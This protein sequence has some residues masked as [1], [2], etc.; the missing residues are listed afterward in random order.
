MKKIVHLIALLTMLT[1][2][3]N[4]Q[5]AIYKKVKVVGTHQQ[6]QS[7]AE[8]G[9]CLDHGERKDG[10]FFVSDF[11]PVEFNAIVKSGLKIEV[12]AED[13][14]LYYRQSNNND[15]HKVQAVNCN[16]NTSAPQYA[17]PANFNLGSMGGFLTY[18]ELLA[19][20]DDMATQYPGL[21]TIKQPIGSDTTFEGR[22]VYFVKISDNANSNEPE[23]QAYYT[24]LHHARE[25]LSM[26]QLVYYMWYLLENYAA[27][28][29][30]QYLVD[31]RELYFIPCVNPDGYLYNELTDPLGGGMWRK[32]RRD[33]LD[34][35]MGVDLNRNYPANWGYDDI[36]SSPFTSGE[37]YRG[38][39][40]ASEPEIQMINSFANAHQFKTGLD[41]HSYGNLL[42]YPWG[43]IP[44][45]ETPDSTVFKSFAAVYTEFNRYKAGT[46]SQTVNYT[47]NG[48]SIDWHYGEQTSKPKN[49]DFTPECGY[50]FW[51]AQSD[52]ISLAQD[53]IHI[54]MLSALVAGS[55]AKV[56]DN[57]PAFLSTT[58]GYL[59]FNFQELGLD[60]AAT[61]TVSVTPLGTT[62]NSV[63]NPVA[64]NNPSLM[65]SISDS[66]S[67]SLNANTVVGSEVKYLLSVNFGTYMK[68][69]T[70]VKIYGAPT[71]LLSDDCNNL[72]N[73]ASGSLWNITSASFVSPATSITDSPLGLYD[74]GTNNELNM[75]AAIN[76]VGA[77][78][79]SLSFYAKWDI[80]A[81][82]DYLQVLAS[83]NN[84]ATWAPLCGKYT[85]PG[86]VNQ[87]LGNP[88]FDGLQN[89]WVKESMS[90]N[91]YLGSDVLIQFRLISDFGNEKDGFYFDDLVVE[92][93]TNAVG[94]NELATNENAVADAI[95]NPSKDFTWISYKIAD[96]E[97][98]LVIYDVTGKQVFSQLLNEKQGSYKLNVNQFNA[99]VYY[100]GIQ[101]Q[102][103][104]GVLKKLIVLK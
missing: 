56:S 6:L 64:Y 46:P 73:F 30:V 70:V 85:H 77:T 34:G 20:L 37:T 100:Y 2:G 21:I 93:L 19:E 96:K 54:D 33:N 18:S 84:G 55:Y 103:S 25:P 39:G 65:Q 17:I 28:P 36:G 69:D 8:A 14:A 4:A 79:A 61:F 22:P 63:G 29:Q 58:T 52:I 59:K 7:L 88:V 76:L 90:L 91:D 89:S 11:N 49:F 97:Q 67:Y 45:F 94:L 99:G 40:P 27:S 75:A 60:T 86:S 47:A 82:Y 66:V 83:D 15:A 26:Q 1:S 44:D 16:S 102:K 72:N 104:K 42:I 78:N 50:S 80:E 13:A 41:F 32:N 23:P 12:I 87:D 68:T 10:V 53:A 101:S 5:Q 81:N 9:V 62:F 92:K 57:S 71:T 74:P 35:T 3:A 48:V 98:A 31:N 38:T 95:P 51:P 43:H 24:A